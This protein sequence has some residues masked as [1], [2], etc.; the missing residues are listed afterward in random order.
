VDLVDVLDCVAVYPDYGNYVEEDST[1]AEK[2]DISENCCV[3]L[4]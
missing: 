1:L 3:N 4:G 2:T